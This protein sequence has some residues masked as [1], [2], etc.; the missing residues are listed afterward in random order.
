MRVP[1]GWLRDFLPGEAPVESIAAALTARGFTVEHVT[2]PPKLDRIVVGRIEA[3]DRHPNADRLQVAKV[4]VGVE[5]LQ[6][7]TGAT[8]VA[9]GDAV[10]IALVGAA[11]FARSTENA[12]GAELKRIRQSVLRG[13]ESAG[14]MC[15]ASELAL[16]GEFDEGILLLDRGMRPGSDF[17]QAVRFSDAIL[18]VEVPSNRPDCLSIVG[19]AREAAAA[20]GSAFSYQPPPSTA[21]TAPASLIGVEIEDPSVCRRLLGQYFRGIKN[22][23]SPL[24]LA[25]RLEAAGVRSHNYFIDVSNYVQIE[26]GQ[27][28]HFYDAAKLRGNKIAARASFD[29]ERILTLDGVERALPVGTPVISDGHGLI[30]IAGILGGQSCAID[31]RTEE[32]FAESPTFVGKRVRRAAIAL[33]LRT[34][35]A[36][37]H[38]R[39]LPLEL[40]DVGLRRAAALLTHAGAI[41]SAVAAGGDEPP[42]ARSVALRPSRVNAILGTRIDVDEMRRAIQPIGFAVTGTET[43]SVTVP[44]WRTDVA[45]EIDLVEEVARG[46]GFDAIAERPS[47]AP[48]QDVDESEFLQ[49]SWLATSIAALGYREVVSVALQGS[50]TASE[51]ERSGLTFWLDLTPI[52]NPLSE[53]QRFL[54]PS[55]LPG[56]LEVA[57]KHPRRLEGSAFF[58]IGHIFARPEGDAVKERRSLFGLRCFAQP[59][60]TTAMD[61]CLLEVKGDVE[62]VLR[63]LSGS[64]GNAAAD[65]LLWA[66]PG[67]AA[68][69]TLEDTPVATF[70]RLHPQLTRAYGLPP[71]SYGFELL[72]DALPRAR[73][74]ASYRAVSRLPGTRRDVAVVVDE[75]IAARD[76]AQAVWSAGVPH[77]ESVRPF[78]EYRGPQT[79]P[80]RKSVALSIMLRKSDAT[81]TDAQADAAM[82]VVVAA[83][84]VHFGAVLREPEGQ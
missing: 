3:L 66:H 64:D 19:L 67:A 6:I 20:M 59:D 10:P 40:C 65:R 53:D 68:V 74:I 42:A 75:A 9:A 33:G 25:L 76:L 60:R 52:A 72:L 43:L 83:L 17:W 50:K 30:G 63:Q 47:T 69:I 46:I 23:R 58:E 21:Q 71:D 41:A 34:E 12:Q 35:G 45:D 82:K 8:N 29:G 44:W 13:V 62:Y 27:P 80:G 84:A 61:R 5:R 49:E 77:L 73:S 54:R 7:V 1:I 2:K 16:P 28:L 11:V 37:R 79:G 26:I 81:I 22:R 70:A 51:W 31:D 57:A 48:P 14:M 38:E 15:S 39:D 32:V 56:L 36:S 24:W 55:L 4:D 78:D 18:G